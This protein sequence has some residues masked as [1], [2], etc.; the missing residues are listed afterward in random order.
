MLLVVP[1]WVLWRV[2][3][4]V[5]RPEQVLRVPPLAQAWVA[6]RV[7]ESAIRGSRN[8]HSRSRVTTRRQPTVRSVRQATPAYRPPHSISNR[9]TNREGHSNE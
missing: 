6:W 8:I 5:I 3:S 9:I 1:C 7:M 4:S 2:R